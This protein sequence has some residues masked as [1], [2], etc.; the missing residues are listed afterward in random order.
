MSFSHIH[1]NPSQKA[2][3]DGLKDRKAILM[4]NGA[5]YKI[6]ELER[7]IA[8]LH[9]TLI[10]FGRSGLGIEPALHIIRPCTYSEIECFTQKLP[11]TVCNE[12]ANRFTGVL[13]GLE[14]DRVATSDIDRITSKAE[15]V[16][17]KLLALAETASKELKEDWKSASRDLANS[18]GSMHELISRVHVLL[19]STIA[20]AQSCKR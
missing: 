7:W 1:L 15:G 11:S 5:L 20:E 4:T 16:V 14:G 12:L 17:P 6:R 8:G 2:Y 18:R 19:R 9:D 13:Y 3:I 10:V